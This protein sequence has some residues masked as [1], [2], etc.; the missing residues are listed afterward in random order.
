MI[1]SNPLDVGSEMSA[2]IDVRHIIVG[3]KGRSTA[4]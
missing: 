3:R 4:L 2:D 1:Q